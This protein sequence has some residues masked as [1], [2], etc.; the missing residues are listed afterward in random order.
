MKG[1]DTPILLGILRGEAWT[2]PLLKRLTG[3]EVAT[4]SANLLELEVIARRD[5]SA[6]RDRRL[7]AL[8][9]L[10]RSLTVVQ[11][12]ERA[13]RLGAEIASKDPM[14]AASGQTW[15]MIGALDASGCSEWWTTQE[16]RWPPGGKA[17]T[18]VWN[19]KVSNHA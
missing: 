10:K 18:V 11:L 4:T 8:E 1:L 2:H 17:K 7:V 14:R 15:H 3:E 6:G 9:R 19:R 5:A 12:D 13:A 16:A